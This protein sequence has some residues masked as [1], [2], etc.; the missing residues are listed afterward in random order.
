MRKNEAI[1]K[2]KMYADRRRG[3][4]PSTLTVGDIVLVRAK[5]ER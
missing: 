3:A 5:K 1:S 2:E 4:K